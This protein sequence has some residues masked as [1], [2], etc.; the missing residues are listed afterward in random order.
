MKKLRSERALEKEIQASA[1]RVKK[2]RAALSDVTQHLDLLDS[3]SDAVND[4]K[5]LIYR[6]LHET[7]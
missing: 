7:E 2:L 3:S 4:A 6:T 1:E 5:E